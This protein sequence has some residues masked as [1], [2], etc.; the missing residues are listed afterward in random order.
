VRANEWLYLL[1]LSRRSALCRGQGQEWPGSAAGLA[2]SALRA[3]PLPAP[4]S[5]TAAL[6]RGGSFDGNRRLVVLPRF[7]ASNQK[8]AE[9]RRWRVAR[10]KNDTKN[11]T[12]AASDF[13]AERR[14]QLT[15]PF[16]RHPF[17]I[18][19]LYS[20]ASK[21]Y[22]VDNAHVSFGSAAVSSSCS[23]GSMR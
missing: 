18:L 12:A 13:A 2:G 9:L 7:L 16:F 8:G 20:C 14:L 10:E 4:H 3:K 15:A 23:A 5:Q 6:P 1:C 19:A 21:R 17:N 11:F 22:V